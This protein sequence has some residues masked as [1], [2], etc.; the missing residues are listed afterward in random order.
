M[1][2]EEQIIEDLAQDMTDSIDTGILVDLY[3]EDGIDVIDFHQGLNLQKVVD[4][5]C[6]DNCGGEWKRMRTYYIFKDPAD[7]TLFRLRWL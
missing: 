6:Q 5:W 7:A 3:R 2:L 1:N 4:L